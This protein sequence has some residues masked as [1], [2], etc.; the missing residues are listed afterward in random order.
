[1][2]TTTVVSYICQRCVFGTNVNYEFQVLK[3]DIQEG[4]DNVVPIPEF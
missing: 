2:F 4:N 1:M 3:R